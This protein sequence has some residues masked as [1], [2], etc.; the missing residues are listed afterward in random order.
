MK[1]ESKTRAGH[2]Q[3]G[4]GAA[5]H[6]SA[7]SM[8]IES[9]RPNTIRDTI[10]SIVVAFIM[11]FVFRAFI[12]EAFI[13]PTGS[14]APSLYGEHGQHR[15]AMCQYPFAYGLREAIPGTPQQATL[16]S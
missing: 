1:T 6:L 15:C 8:P 3:P 16:A 14:M 12:V 2:E 7:E 5:A 10:E 4:G 13:I 9:A 11:A